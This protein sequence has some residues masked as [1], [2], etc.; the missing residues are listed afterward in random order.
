M[1]EFEKVESEERLEL[2]RKMIIAG[3]FYPN[4][5]VRVAKDERDALRE[6]SGLDPFKT[7]VLSGVPSNQGPLYKDQ[8]SALFSR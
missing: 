7:V 4:Y 2:L 3:A 5:F 6:V 1:A 8:I